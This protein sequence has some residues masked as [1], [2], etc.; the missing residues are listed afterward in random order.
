MLPGITAARVLA[1]VPVAKTHAETIYS[2]QSIL[3]S[4][5]RI[6]R[7]TIPTQQDIAFSTSVITGAQKT[8][9]VSSSETVRLGRQINKIISVTSRQRI[10]TNQLTPAF[11]NAGAFLTNALTNTL[12]PVMPATRSNG[13]ILMSFFRV[14]GSPAVSVG[15]GWTI[16]ENFTGVSG[17]NTWAWRI[18]DGTE[19]NPT[20]TWTGNQVAM[21]RIVQISGCD[22]TTPY[23]NFSHQFAGSTNLQAPSITTTRESSLILAYLLDGST[24]G[25]IPTPTGYTNRAATT[26]AS[27]TDEVA[28]Q[29]APL[30]SGQSSTAISVTI[31]NVVWVSFVV[32]MKWGL[33]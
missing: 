3:F 11:V 23:G 12:T 14:G 25:S 16:V 33:N 31:P 32:E 4:R 24:A 9:N 30:H 5:N 2:D 18:V 20:Y 6:Q 8:I 21:G 10:S 15:G 27:A 19:A 7:L 1:Y 26:T 13:N 22:Q 28:T 17:R 29:D